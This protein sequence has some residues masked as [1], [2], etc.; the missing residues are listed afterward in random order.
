[1]PINIISKNRYST[2]NCRRPFVNSCQKPL[3]TSPVI[4]STISHGSIIQL[5]VLHRTLLGIGPSLPGLIRCASSRCHSCLVRRLPV[6]LPDF[7]SP[8]PSPGTP[9]CLA[10]V[11]SNATRA[12]QGHFSALNPAGLGRNSCGL[13]RFNLYT[14]CNTQ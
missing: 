8:P 10:L 14:R 3:Y 2:L 9:R 4:Q 13:A 11:A 12:A 5:N 7:Q 6:S 1:M